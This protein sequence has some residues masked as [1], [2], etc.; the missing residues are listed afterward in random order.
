MS[1]RTPSRAVSYSDEMRY[2]SSQPP[3]AASCSEKKRPLS[4]VSPPAP[5]DT[6]VR[7][8]TA[9]HNLRYSVK[10]PEIRD[11]CGNEA[12]Y[13]EGYVFRYLTSIAIAAMC[14]EARSGTGRWSMFTADNINKLLTT[15]PAL[16]LDEH[17]H[18]I[19]YLWDV[20]YV[21]DVDRFYT[22]TS[23][24][25]CKAVPG[26]YKPFAL[27]RALT[28]KL[29]FPGGV[30]LLKEV[31]ARNQALAGEDAAKRLKQE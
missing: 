13:I 1:S 10:C 7:L 17:K 20:P 24:N 15:I 30:A 12:E 23:D 11:G 5:T 9:V 18:L 19:A 22:G 26:A 14:D 3:P 16:S 27:P 21:P 29:E 8:T 31:R 2:K 4:E 25:Y 28:D 6:D